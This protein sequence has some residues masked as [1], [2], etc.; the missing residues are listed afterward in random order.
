MSFK[1]A[2]H[3]GKFSKE[4]AISLTLKDQYNISISVL[5]SVIRSLGLPLARITYL[6]SSYI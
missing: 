2:D 1:I 4:N 5:S 6:K 3:V